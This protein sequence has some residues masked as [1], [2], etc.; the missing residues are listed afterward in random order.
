MSVDVHLDD[1]S[2][3]KKLAKKHMLP[4]VTFFLIFKET[5]N[6]ANLKEYWA[7]YNSQL[8]SQAK[9]FCKLKMKRMHQQIGEYTKDFN[10]NYKRL[11]DM[12]NQLNETIIQNA[13]KK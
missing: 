1:L 9:Y 11:S 5:E 6:V 4:E 7:F 10:L 3:D 2:K 12:F 13:K 8:I